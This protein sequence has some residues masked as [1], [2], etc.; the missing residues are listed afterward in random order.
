LIS[1]SDKCITHSQT[2]AVGRISAGPADGFLIGVE[3]LTTITRD[4]DF[5]GLQEYGGASTSGTV[6]LF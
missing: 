2:G 1:F 5:S 3:Q 6:N 4:H